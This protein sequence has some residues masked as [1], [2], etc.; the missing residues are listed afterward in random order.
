M[1]SSIWL[2]NN[3]LMHCDHSCHCTFPP[4]YFTNQYLTC[5]NPSDALLWWFTVV[6]WK[7]TVFWISCAVCVRVG[8]LNFGVPWWNGTDIRPAVDRWI[9]RTI[10]T[11]NVLR[12]GEMQN[13][14]EHSARP[15]L[16]VLFPFGLHRCLLTRTPA[17]HVLVTLHDVRW[18][19]LGTKL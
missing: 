19:G 12:C 6:P 11:W 10:L 5:G 9:A 16:A 8:G 13:R 14:N 1:L 7:K 18:F 2:N 3:I 4:S 17:H 15:R